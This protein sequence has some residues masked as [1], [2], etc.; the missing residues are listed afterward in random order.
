MLDFLE[1]PSMLA[2]KIVNEDFA[3]LNRLHQNEKAMARLGG[4]R[5]AEKNRQYLHDSI[6]HW[7]KQG[8]GLWIF[9]TK[10]NA[11]IGRGGLRYVTLQEVA[12]IE[13]A[14][15]LMPEYWG[16]GLATEIA[17]LSIQV[18]STNLKLNSII[19]YTEET[20]EASRRVMA[21]TGFLYEKTLF[22]Y[23]SPHVIYRLSF[24]RQVKP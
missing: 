6:A 17:K 11:F 5:P 13:V 1:T 10:E 8:F 15:A 22:L 19:C 7:Q 2:S 23:E 12:E 18:A 16:Q 20:H 9:R 4:V 3:D 24:P 14:Y 21:K